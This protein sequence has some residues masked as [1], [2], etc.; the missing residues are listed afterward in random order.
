M[1]NTEISLV[2]DNSSYSEIANNT[3]LLNSFIKRVKEGQSI[4]Y[5]LEKQIF[6]TMGG[7]NSEKVLN[8]IELLRWIDKKI[9]NELCQ[10]PLG[11]GLIIKKEVDMCGELAGLPSFPLSESLLSSQ[12][13]TPMEISKFKKDWAVEDETKKNQDVELNKEEQKDFLSPVWNLSENEIQEEYNSFNGIEDERKYLHLVRTQLKS[14][15]KLS[16]FPEGI[17]IEV[18]FEKNK[19][20]YLKCFVNVIYFTMIRT[21]LYEKIGKKINTKNDV[22]D[23]FQIIN[24]AYSQFLLTEDQEMIELCDRLKSCLPFRAIKIKDFLN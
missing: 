21:S 15:T 16:P 1:R 4:V 11:S 18:I 12:L 22:I 6:G 2:I 5:F 10:I 7:G 14:L 24:T 3:N 9:G 23:T 19:Y 13:S 20:K 17:E 8:R